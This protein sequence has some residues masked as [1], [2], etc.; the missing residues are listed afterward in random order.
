MNFEN[1]V[2]VV[3]AYNPISQGVW[4]Y[5]VYKNIDEGFDKMKEMEEDENYNH[6]MWNNNIIKLK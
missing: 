4:I 5:G 3:Y 6:L 2:M 1:C